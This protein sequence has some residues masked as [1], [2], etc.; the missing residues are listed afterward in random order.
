MVIRRQPH[1]AL[2]LRDADEI[3]EERV[4]EEDA[5][6]MNTAYMSRRRG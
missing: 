6:T 5:I 2:E 4:G 1:P 3:R